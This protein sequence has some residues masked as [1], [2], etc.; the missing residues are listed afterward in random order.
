MTCICGGTYQYIATAS[1]GD[2]WIN[3]YR[4]PKCEREIAETKYRY[5]PTTC[6]RH[7]WEFLNWNFKDG[8]RAHEIYWEMGCDRCGAKTTKRF[9]SYEVGLRQA[10]DME[11][12]RVLRA[13]DFNE[14]TVRFHLPKEDVSN[15]WT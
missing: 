10:V 9:D 11:D 13:L 12:P 8:P 3:V 2:H 15:F 7:H 1:R 6:P 4:C 14:R 5:T